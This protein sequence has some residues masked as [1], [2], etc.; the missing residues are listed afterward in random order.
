MDEKTVL[1]FLLAAPARSI[2]YRP[3]VSYFMARLWFRDRR[4]FWE[5]AKQ[6]SERRPDVPALVAITAARAI[7]DLTQTNDDLLPIFEMPE[8]SR[9]RAIAFLLRAIQAMKGLESR[10]RYVWLHFLILS[11]KYVDKQF[12][13]ESVA[14]VGAAS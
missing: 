2:F 10:N 8:A 12:L 6:F 1:D 7:F 9:L 5:V 4:L 11:L 13:N 3:S 14:I